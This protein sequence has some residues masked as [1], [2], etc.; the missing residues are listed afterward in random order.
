VAAQNADPKLVFTIGS[1]VNNDRPFRCSYKPSNDFNSPDSYFAGM[2]PMLDSHNSMGPA[3][4]A[5]YFLAQGASGDR[6][7]ETYS[8]FLP[9]GMKG[10]GND[11]AIK[12]WF[13]AMATKV[14]DPTSGYYEIREAMIASAKELHG[15]NSPE[16]AAVQNAFAAIAVGS[17]AGENS[18]ARI[19]LADPEGAPA[20]SGY[21][22]VAPCAQPVALPVPTVTAVLDPTY[23]WT[24]VQTR[25]DKNPRSHMGFR[26]F[27]YSATVNAYSAGTP[28]RS[29]ARA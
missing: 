23:T 1:Q 13:H 9:G 12:L 20:G 24:E 4:R 27:S 6:T 8:E 11:K 17:P 28:M 10:V 5:F 7:Q 14:T 29:R 3:N 15:E 21:L 2:G 19:Q 25:H 22:L 26:G 18:A 16:A